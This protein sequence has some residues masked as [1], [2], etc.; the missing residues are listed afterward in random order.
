MTVSALIFLFTASV[1]VWPSMAA[2]LNL[3][4]AFFETVSGV[5]TTGLTVTATVQGKPESFL[6]ARA[7]MQWIGGLG[8]VVL[9]LAAMIQPG[10]TA[11]RLGDLEDYEDDLVGGTR[12][13][14]RR[15]LIVYGILTAAGVISLML[16]GVQWFNAVL[17]SLAAVSTGGFSPQASS[18]SDMGGYGAAPMVI[19]LSIAGG[20]A[21][22]SYHRMV[23]DNWR[24]LPRDRQLQGLLV[25]GLVTALVVSWFLRSRG[26]FDWP[27][28]LYHGFLNA[29]SAQSTAGF[30]S[31]AIAD[32]DPG[33]K[34]T[35]IFSMMVGGSSGSTAGG[36]KVVRLLILGR[37]VYLMVRRTAMPR[38]AV[39]QAKLNGQ[40]LEVD[41][42][43]NALCLLLVFLIFTVLSW[44][45]FVAMGYQPLDSLFE[46]VSAIGTVGLSAGISGPELHP[47]LKGVLCA[48]MLLGRLEILAWLV[49]V[50]PGTWFGRRLEE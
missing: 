42:I 34:L 41:E 23:H 24:I 37:L 11:K 46:V 18:I 39:A 13:H 35:L 26:G 1:M 22:V 27:Q 16:L 36:M 49:L 21:L 47:F 3:L 2:G 32:L 45:P 7:W 50:Y 48:D 31:I 17:Y 5:T 20:V 8:I 4:D 40:R 6:F 19:F 12:A 28:A 29:F 9:S 38:Q 33:S 15:I 44:F 25:F 14:A 30:S 43:Q 10:L